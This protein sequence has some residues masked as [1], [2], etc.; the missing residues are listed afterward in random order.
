MNKIEDPETETN[1][2]LGMN[3]KLPSCSRPPHKLSDLKVTNK[4][5]AK[6]EPK[7]AQSSKTLLPTEVK[8]HNF[9][10]R[11]GSGIFS[12]GHDIIRRITQRLTVSETTHRSVERDIGRISKQIAEKQQIAVQLEELL[13]KETSEN[14]ILNNLLLKYAMTCMV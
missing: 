9:G 1:L 4:L 10:E 3:T 7:R 2:E 12:R 13:R 5:L 11:K 14:L 8:P 6:P